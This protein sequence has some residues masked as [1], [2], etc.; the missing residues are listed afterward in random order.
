MSSSL[1]TKLLT[2]A[3]ANAGLIALLG[4]SPF[5]WY[6]NQFLQGSGYPAVVV[7][8]ISN[9]NMHVATGRLPTSW[10][11]VQFTIWGGPSDAGTQA[12]ET[13][14]A[15]LKAFLLTFNG[16]GIAG[17]VAYPNEIVNIRD[18]F[19]P[20]PDPGIFQKQMDAMIYSNETV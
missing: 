16:T 4:S 17:L 12:C 10:T 1:K 19:C 3:A 13:V 8:I 9:P 6:D 18:A 14:I 5:R 15:A 20:Q 2:Q 7:Q 11:R